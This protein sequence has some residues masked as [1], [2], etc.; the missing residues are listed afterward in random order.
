MSRSNCG[1]SSSSAWRSASERTRLECAVAMRYGRRWPAS[2][3]AMT[4]RAATVSARYMWAWTTSAR[5]SARWAARAPTAIESSGSSMTRTATPRP[6]EL[7]HGAPRRQRDDRDVVAGRIEPRHER[8]EVFLRAAVRAR[9]EHLDDPDAMPARQL[10]TLDRGEARVERER[11]AHLSRPAAGPARAGSAR[12][13]RP[14]RTCRA[15][16]R[17]GS[18]A[19]GRRR[20][21]RARSGRGP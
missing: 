3:R 21:G 20:P 8:E 14:S 11:C 19:G 7:A 1:V 12:R 9:R 16:C 13:R 15:R 18:R 2:P 17:A 5:T 4:A 6:L 10:R